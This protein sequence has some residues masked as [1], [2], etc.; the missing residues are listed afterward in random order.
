M[1]SGSKSRTAWELA[2]DSNQTS[3]MSISLRN[4]VWPQEQAV[5]AGRISSAVW[6]YQ[7]SADSLMN[8]STTSLLMAA[9]FSGSPHL[10]QR[11]TAMGTPQMR[12]REMHQSGRVATMFVMRS[13]P[14]AGSQVTRWIS[15]KAL[16]RN[17]VGACEEMRGSLDSALRAS[18]GMT[19][20]GA[21]MGV[22]M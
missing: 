7:A 16:W 11:K 4:S 15:S 9:F 12:W 13:W 3:R 2:P 1:V 8:R 14:H 19:T 18:L 6:M 20:L 17:V 10:R 21:G 5:P 22:S